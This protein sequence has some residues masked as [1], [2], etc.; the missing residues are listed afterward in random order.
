M[1]NLGNKNLT[2]LKFI[3]VSNI[4][5]C[6]LLKECGRNEPILKNNQCISTYCTEEQF[7]SGECIINE[8][9]TKTQWLNNIIKFEKTKGFFSLITDETYETVLFIVDSSDNKEKI[10]LYSK[11]DGLN[12]IFKNNKN[13]CIHYIKI[14]IDDDYEVLNPKTYILYY[15]KQNLNYIVSIGT[16]NSNISVLNVFNN[17]NNY[18]LFDSS[19]FLNDSTRII[20]G[21]DSLCFYDGEDYFFYST[22]TTK[23]NDPSNYYLSFYNY[24][25][26]NILNNE[27]DFSF[28]FNSTEDIDL[29][30]GN[31]VSCT[32]IDEKVRHISC[33]YLSQDNFYTITLVQN[34]N[35]NITVE[36]KI[37][38][39]NPSNSGQ[40]NIYFLKAISLG[41]YK[42]IYSYYSGND[43]NLPTFLMKKINSNDFSLDNLYTRFPVLYLYDYV[44]NN[45]IKYT[46]LAVISEREFFFVSTN[47]NKDILIIANIFIYKNP[48]DIYQ[49]I[50]RYY[51]IKLKEY[52]YI[53]ILNGFKAVTYNHTYLIIGFDFCNYDSCQNNGEDI[54]F[55]NHFS[56]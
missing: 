6:G 48:S 52:Y 2:F 33:F 37:I 9:T 35:N 36:S 24:N 20:E 43:D 10:Y 8:A 49:L 53:Q 39:G 5:I 34:S 18:I 45:N 11:I 56:I 7:K 23:S 42:V 25:I 1:K 50:I 40:D 12:C 54:K 16:S 13:N 4:F 46:D 28:R 3:L 32:I 19:F 55:L 29:T 47:I 51:T 38:V 14:G 26:E 21:I 41:N 31:Y 22:I 17:A 15:R 30:K 27:N 44:F